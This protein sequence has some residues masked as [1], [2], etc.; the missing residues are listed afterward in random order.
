MAVKKES[1]AAIL[2]VP[3]VWTCFYEGVD[4]VGKA[5]GVVDSAP[6]DPSYSPI[7]IPTCMAVY[8]NAQIS[9]QTI[10]LGY[11][12]ELTTICTRLV[13]P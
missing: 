7:A 11:L 13:L 3:L 4:F 6:S 8:T 5:V 9:S 12:K 1:R 10:R 2:M